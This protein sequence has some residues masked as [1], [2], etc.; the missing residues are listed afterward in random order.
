MQE[1]LLFNKL[2][3]EVYR[4][5]LNDLDLLQQ[6][7]VEKDYTRADR[8]KI[9]LD[10]DCAV[11]PEGDELMIELLD[12]VKCLVCHGIIKDK[13]DSNVCDNCNHMVCKQCSKGYRNKNECPFCRINPIVIRKLTKVELLAIQKIEYKCKV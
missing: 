1:H 11:C 10:S 5:T 12:L 3:R 13:E 6:M 4:N 9:Y 7:E 2:Y 8:Y